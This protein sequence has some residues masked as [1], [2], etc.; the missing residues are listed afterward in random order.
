VW[1][2]GGQPKATPSPDR[3]T[4][5][6]FT[7]LYRRRDAQTGSWDRMRYVADGAHARVAVSRGGVPLIAWEGDNGITVAR[8]TPGTEGK[9]LRLRVSTR[10]AYP[11]LALAAEGPLWLAWHQAEDNGVLQIHLARIRVGQDGKEGHGRPDRE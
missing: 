9:L 2:T 6:E 1:A 8:L 3:Q 11:S 10:G 5:S 4:E 7:V